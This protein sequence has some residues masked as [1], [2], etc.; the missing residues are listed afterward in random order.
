MKIGDGKMYG[1]ELNRGE[2]GELE[3]G[4]WGVKT[5]YVECKT[6]QNDRPDK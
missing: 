2:E 4:R 3:R 6:R 5:F 1:R